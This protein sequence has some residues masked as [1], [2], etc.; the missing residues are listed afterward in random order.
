MDSSFWAAVFWS[1]VPTAVVSTLF[2][3]IL[4]SIIRSDRTER[5]IY[6][7]IQAEERAKRGL[8]PVPASAP[9]AAPAER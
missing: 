7:R 5:R 1:L 4:R 6:A 8:P 9:A 3:W 2:F